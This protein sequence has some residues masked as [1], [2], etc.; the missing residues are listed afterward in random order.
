[1]A[2]CVT[3][4][5]DVALLYAPSSVKQDDIMLQKEQREV[6]KLA[7]LLQ[8]LSTHGKMSIALSLV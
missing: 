8:T 3:S 2:V 4:D 1:M 7:S 5:F 6:T